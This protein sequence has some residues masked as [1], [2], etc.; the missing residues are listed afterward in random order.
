MTPRSALTH[1]FDF[2]SKP[3][4][5]ITVDSSPGIINIFPTDTS[6]SNTLKIDLEEKSAQTETTTSNPDIDEL[7]EIP[8]TRKSSFFTK[9]DFAYEYFGLAAMAAK[10]ASPYMEEVC[11]VSTGKELFHDAV[12]KKV[13][14]HRW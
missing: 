7:S 14:F 10:V 8:Q 1:R 5:K 6:S 3:K 9:K 2:E 11:H 4:S 13:P 12:S